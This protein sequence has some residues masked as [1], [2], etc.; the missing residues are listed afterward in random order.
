[1]KSI[2][3]DSPPSHIIVHAGTNDIP[4]DL[5]NNCI[6]NIWSLASSIKERFPGSKIGISSIAVRHDADLTDRISTVN[7]QLQE[8]C[9]KNGFD[10]INNSNVDNTE[11]NYTLTPRDL[12][13]WQRT[14]LSFYEEAT[15]T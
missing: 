11:A 4:V 1:M 7:K 15:Q 2:K 8:L 5:D 12:P 9:V 6:K 14:S 3:V 10:F 13:S